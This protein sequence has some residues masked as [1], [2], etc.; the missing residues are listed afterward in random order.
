MLVLTIISY[1]KYIRYA[2]YQLIICIVSLLPIYFIE[3]KLIKNYILSYVA[4]GISILNFILT[5]ILSSKDVK[6]AI[7][8]KF[9]V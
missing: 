2:I 5:I 4:I 3:E 6:L 1:K 9:H 8:R 7:I